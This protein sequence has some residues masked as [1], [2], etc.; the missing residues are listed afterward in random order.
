M[1]EAEKAKRKLAM[2]QGSIS[3]SLGSM[4]KVLQDTQKVLDET[5]EF[6]IGKLKDV[7]SEQ[8]S[9]KILETFHEID[10]NG[11]GVLDKQ[12]LETAFVKMG[13]KLTSVELDIWLEAFDDDD[14]GTVDTAEFEHMVRNLMEVECVK[15]CA[16]CEGRHTKFNIAAAPNGGGW[17]AGRTASGTYTDPMIAKYRE[18]AVETRAELSRTESTLTESRR[19][20]KESERYLL[21]QFSGMAE[22]GHFAERMKSTFDMFD[23]DGSGFIDRNELSLAFRAMGRPLSADEVDAWME[24]LDVDGNGVIDEMEF[25]HIIRQLLKV[26]CKPGQCKLCGDSS[27]QNTPRTVTDGPPSRTPSSGTAKASPG[28]NKTKLKASEVSPNRASSQANTPIKAHNGGGSGKPYL[29]SSPVKPKAR[30]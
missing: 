5:S 24:K 8:L 17:P 22:G 2:L 3:N 12:E 10:A 11:N 26:P 18:L 6:L 21:G 19:I 30:T 25:E 27:V 28:P 14:D 16:I 15:G 1:D 13:R 7:P 4:N 9:A 29:S 23:A 20:L